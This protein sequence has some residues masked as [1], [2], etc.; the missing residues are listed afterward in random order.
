MSY[1][2]VTTRCQGGT[3]LAAHIFRAEFQTSLV[4]GVPGGSAVLRGVR[5]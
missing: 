5:E 2:Q 1:F 3:L 4:L